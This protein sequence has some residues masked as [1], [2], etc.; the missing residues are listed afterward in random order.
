[1]MLMEKMMMA[2]KIRSL[3]MVFKMIYLVRE[4]RG[5]SRVGLRVARGTHMYL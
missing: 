4:T 3:V 2:R 5:G 1:M